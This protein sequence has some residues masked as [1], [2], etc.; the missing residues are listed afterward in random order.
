M[1]GFH[2]AENDGLTSGKYV[3]SS[4]YSWVSSISVCRSSDLVASGAANGYVRLWAIG[5]DTKDVKP[6]YN[7]PLV[8]ETVKA[9]KSQSFLY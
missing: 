8:S 1:F 7:L 9:C 5:S 3:S 2:H 6:L 4:A